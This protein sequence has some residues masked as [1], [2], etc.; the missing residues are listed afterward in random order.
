LHSQTDPLLECL[1]VLGS[2][3]GQA[4]TREALIAGLP[5]SNRILDPSLFSRSARRLGLSSRI[6][7]KSLG[8]INKSLL[9]A[10]LL[11]ED[12]QACLLMEVTADRNAKVIFPEL[13]DALAEISLD[14]L[15]S[16]YIGQ[17]IFVRPGF[18]FDQRSPE[19]K[20]HKVQHHWFWSSLKENTNLYRDVLLAAFFINLLAVALPL[21]TMNVYDR[22]IPNAAL[23]TLWTLAVGV[24]IVVFA[25][26]MLRTIRGYYLDLANKRID[27]QLSADIM[28]RV[29]GIRMELRPVSAGS[30]AANLRSFETIRDFITSATITAVIDLPF[31][32]I[33]IGL[34]FWIAGPMAIPVLAGVLFVI[35]FALTTQGKMQELTETTYR[36]SALRNSTLIESLVGLDT[37]KAMAAESIMQK[38]WE[39]SASF[40]ARV[41]IQLRTLASFNMNLVMWAQQSVT[42]AVIISGVYLIS[43]GELSMGG[44]IACSM[45]TGRAMS[46]L[47]AIAGL[48][49]QFHNAK[50]AYHSLNEIMHTPIERPENARFIHRQ[51]F[52][53]KIE[54]KNV[55]FTYPGNDTPSLKNVSFI[56]EPGEHV[57]VLGRIGSG[58]STLK[59][60][61]IGMYQ[62]SEGS[63]LID[64][65]DIR[66]LDLAE[67]RQQVGYVAQ[68]VTLFY[69]SLRE[70]IV[71]A[72]PQADDEAIIR[73]AEFAHLSD[74][75][76]THPKGFDMLIGERGESL[77]GG[78]RKSVAL[79]RS[80]IHDPQILLLDEPTGSMDH[81]T[82]TW[83]TRKL[84]AYG[85]GRSLLISTHRTSI[86]NLVDRIL[87][88]D[89]GK[90]VADGP[91]DSVAEA[92]RE[93]RIGK[94]S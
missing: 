8:S 2:Y 87:V 47:G 92:L 46:P 40:L 32:F 4:T 45:L 52:Q 42:I 78:Q 14:E 34:I 21:F 28:E 61:V 69:G 59:K 29:L 20:Q 67:L 10:V 15:E 17:V 26:A 79:A 7:K 16:K 60:L 80:V 6:F 83:V 25:D 50:T 93:G 88:I 73:A 11:L 53:G 62:P 55:T 70:N 35:L 33:F 81:S 71:L 89:S 31:T 57:A 54:F 22:V 56:I 94:A 65:I 75:I 63:I 19:L 27:I 86:L 30:F 77:S 85:K 3:Y 58:K 41:S 24:I 64:G 13:G 12:D 76:N 66:Q 37:V 74:F 38:R 39:H 5:L 68:D 90:V 48:L 23:E 44:L 84:K 91:R 51:K 82:E 1:L 49:A 72:H 18:R 36:A 9:P 43:E